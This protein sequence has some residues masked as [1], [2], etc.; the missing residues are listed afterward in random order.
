M[1]HLLSKSVMIGDD[2]GD[3]CPWRKHLHRNYIHVTLSLIPFVWFILRN[4]W[5][6][7]LYLPNFIPSFHQAQDY[8]GKTVYIFSVVAL[9]INH[10]VL[11]LLM[12]CSCC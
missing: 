8:C 11:G 2:N 5:V 3:E 1:R 9:F 10:T 6:L 4:K 7:S 12:L